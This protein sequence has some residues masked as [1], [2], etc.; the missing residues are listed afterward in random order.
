MNEIS[1]ADFK[2]LQDARDPHTL[3]DV[4]EADELAIAS[5][6]G[7]LW[8]PMSEVPHRLSELPN[9]RQI[10]VMC[11][12]GARSARI[13]A[14]LNASGYPAAVNL[15]GGIHAWSLAVDASVPVYD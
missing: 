15:S 3:L 14:F 8:I 10:I 6:P 12:L 7:A 5:I 13:T 11:H 4:R 9:D 1:V 2:K